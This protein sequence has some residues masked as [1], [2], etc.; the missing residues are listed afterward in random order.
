VPVL[1]QSTTVLDAAVVV[2][3]ALAL[4]GVLVLAGLLLNVNKMLGRLGAIRRQLQEHQDAGPGAQ[5]VEAVAQ[6][7]SMAVSLDR[8]AERAESIDGKLDEIRRRSPGSSDPALSAA[9][10]ALREGLESLKAPLDEIRDRVVRTDAERLADEIRRTLYARGYE[11]VVIRTDLSAV[12]RA[13]EDRV[14][15]EVARAGEK[16]KG[17]VVVR[18]GAV[19]DS[20]VSGTYEMFP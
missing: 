10:L 18:D 6:L 4:V 7:Q 12:S 11:S 17:Y 20:K 15:V 5:L 16:A 14:Q 9:A 13:G 19:V 8:V 3:A 1:A 2:L